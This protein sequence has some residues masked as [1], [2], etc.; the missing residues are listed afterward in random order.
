MT[1]LRRPRGHARLSCAEAV[2][3]G[4]CQ[5]RGLSRA[6]GCRAVDMVSREGVLYG[7]RRPDVPRRGTPL[8]DPWRKNHEIWRAGAATA[9]H[10]VRRT[11][12]A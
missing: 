8:N 2:E 7:H 11:K 10:L 5:P 6:G 9:R 1:R 4:A 3:T 12:I